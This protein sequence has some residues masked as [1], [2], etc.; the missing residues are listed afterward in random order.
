MVRP[1]TD[2][3]T[4][5]NVSVVEERSRH[6]LIRPEGTLDVEEENEHVPK[7]TGSLDGEAA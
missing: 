4:Y 2:V 5:A 3:V 7:L 1:H 6:A